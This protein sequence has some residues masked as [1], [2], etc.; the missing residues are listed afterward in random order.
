MQLNP[1]LRFYLFLI[2]ILFLINI[3]TWQGLVLPVMILAAL[4]GW[5]GEKLWKRIKGYFFFLPVM[6]FF[7][8]FISWGIVGNRLAHVLTQE[9]LIMTKF[10]GLLLCS[11]FYTL[12]GC[13]DRFLPAIRTLWS[14]L[15]LSWR[16][17]EESFVFLSLVLRFFP[18]VRREWQHTRDLQSALG[19]NSG[20]SLRSKVND[21]SGTLPGI[22]LHQFTRAEEIARLMVVRGYGKSFPRT[23]AFPVPWTTGDS[24][25]FVMVTLIAGLMVYVPTL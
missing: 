8:F 10:S 19:M 5:T 16:W 24:M 9:L 17:V 20:S 4:A 13:T 6:A 11:G 25:I 23:V 18:T 1:I 15:G 3:S 7:Y 14:G 22:L 21:I 12:Y 2:S